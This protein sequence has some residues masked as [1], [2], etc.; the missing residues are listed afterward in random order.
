MKFD[1]EMP[2]EKL[3]DRDQKSGA[4]IFELMNEFRRGV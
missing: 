3:R 2:K 4:R 1:D